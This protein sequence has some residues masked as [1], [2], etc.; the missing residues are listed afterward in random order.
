MIPWELQ[1]RL[2]V[3]DLD[4][5]VLKKVMRKERIIRRKIWKLNENRTR[6]KFEKRVKELVSTNA[7]DLWKTFKEGVPKAC[8]ELFGKK[9]SRRDQG[10]MWWWNEE[11]KDTI[12]RK[13]A[14][15]KKLCRFPSKENKTQYKHTRNQTKK[16]VARA[17]RMEANQELKN[18]NQNSNSVFYFLR[19]MKKEGKDVEGGRCLRRGSGRLGFIEKDRAKIWKELMEKIMNEENKWD[20]MVETDLVE[21]PVEKVACNEIVEA[22]QSMKSGKTTGP[23]EVSVE[24]IVA[25]GKIGVEV[26]MELCQRVL[27]D[28]G[29]PDEW[30]T[31]VIVPIFKGNGDVKS[32]GS[33]RGV[34][35]LEHA[36]KIVERVLERRIR[37]LVNLNK[38]LFGFMP[39]KG[40]A[41]AIFIVRRMQEEYQKKDK[42]LYICF[43]DMEKV[44]DRVPRKVME[45]A[46]RKK[47]L[48]EVIVRAVMS[49]YDGA[50]TR[51]IVGSA[52]S[53][54]FEVKVGVHQG[55]VL[56][57][58]LFAIVVDVITENARKG[59]VNKLLYADDLVMMSANM[60][61]LKERFRNWKD[62]LKRKGLKVNTRKTKLIVSGSEG[63]LFKSKI[64][65]RGVCEKR[66]MANSMLC[67]K[68]GN[69]VHGKCAKIKRATARLAMHFVCLKCKGIMEGT[70]D[71]I[72]KLCDEE[73]TVNEF[74]YLEDRLNTSGSCE[75]AVTARVRIGW[76]R[77][78]ECGELLFGN[79]FPLKMKGKVYRCC[80]RS[81]ILYGSE[82]WC[83][84]ENEKTILRRTERALVRAM[85]GQKVVDRKTS[86][87]QMGMLGLNETIERF[88]TVN[89]VRWHGHVLRRDDDSVL[90]V[91][92]NLKVSGKRK[93]GRPKKTWRKQVEE[94]TEKIGLKKEDALRRDKWRDGV[95]AIAEGIR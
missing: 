59:V 24:M 95:R 40:T 80:V 77:F 45:W 23:S 61:D 1:H 5:K 31:N 48:S 47:G 60:E 76:V 28:R 38:M 74:C 12:T 2:V 87:E 73:E 36:M 33:Y 64:D 78:R 25:S 85:C 27:D 35:L 9:K 16:I 34:K 75:A 79:R 8:E 70:M 22:I 67:T 6:V 11:V 69:W 44:F 91:A 7:R 39:G 94:E 92:L 46:M 63:E 89:G 86:E 32:C 81:A 21:E 68:C 93:R 41:D 14:A 82:T 30:K 58:L 4:K 51:V 90:R 10:D 88:A 83:Q 19:R 56:S 52:Y 66:V 49:L 84:K 65:P 62:E 13:K 37:M 72:E 43:V 53:E 54:E 18:F 57:P 3:V 15:F 50:K 26:M 55:S 29:M 20:R 42:K 71:S 17:M